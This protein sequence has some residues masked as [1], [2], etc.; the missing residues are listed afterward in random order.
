MARW[1]QILTLVIAQ[2]SSNA[3]QISTEPLN[4]AN[5]TFDYVIV[6]G[7]TAGL[8]IANRLTEHPRTTVLVVEA[9]I[10]VV[11]DPRV[12]DPGNFAG[13]DVSDLDWSY[14]TTNQTFGGRSLGISAGKVLGGSSCIN[15]MQWTRG[16]VSQYD[17]IEKLGNPGWNFASFQ[18][19]M[20]KA[21]SFHT[22]TQE[23]LDLGITY[24]PSAHGN[25]GRVVTG[26]PN[27]YPCPLCTLWDAFSNA[28]ATAVPSISTGD[29]DQCSGDPRGYAR[30]SYSIIPGPSTGPDAGNNI[31]SSSVKSY[32]HSL[33]PTDR[34]NLHILTGHTATKIIWDPK[35]LK[36]IPTP[37]AVTFRSGNSSTTFSAIVRKEVIVTAGAI[38]T[39]KFLE[40]SGIGNKTLL[41]SLQIPVVVDLPS[42]GT[43][44]QDQAGVLSEYPAAFQMNTSIIHVPAGGAAV[45]LTLTD[46]LGVDGAQKY[47]TELKATITERANAIV[48]AGAGVNFAG[49]EDMLR[50]QAKQF[51]E[52]NAP[53][54][55][56]VLLQSTGLQLFGTN[57]WILL[58]QYRG[59]VHIASS[60]P[61]VHPT[62][63]PNYLITPQDFSLL[64]NASMLVR[65]IAN[66]PSLKSLYSVELLPGSSVESEEDF[67]KY[68][69]DNYV[70]VTHEIGTASML[71]RAMG[72]TVDSQLR[73]YGVQGV[74]VADASILPIQ[75]SAHL[76]STIYGIA[77]KA[78][79]LIKAE[80]CQM[81]PARFFDFY[82]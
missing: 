20:K 68:V 34:P 44:M 14:K 7:G 23:Q 5:H 36:K 79:D 17:A 9:G 30:C 22:P 73:V 40:L 69:H 53:V 24:F 61:S 13:P 51:D 71:P 45:F 25:T 77:E 65:R 8:T 56:S 21:E 28:T 57:T 41:E 70:T 76:S 67:T 58:P 82:E 16:T 59:T 38:G 37:S 1:L 31:R 19:Y 72:G 60:D 80:E 27:P 63:N 75:I 74:R 81:V 12:T 48:E 46:M 32:I 3:Y 33:A 4:I 26:F 18:K 29:I 66:V 15:G 49:V 54:V 62:V 35:S 52:E 50:I 43:N 78:A 64:V 6:G 39:P 55:E 47:V 11:D 2:L 42:V 10:D